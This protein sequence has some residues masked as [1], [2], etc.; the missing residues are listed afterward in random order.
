MKTGFHTH[1]SAL[2]ELYLNGF[3][4]RLYIK[5]DDLIHPIVSGNKW[6]KLKFVIIKAQAEGKNHLVTFGGAYSNH[7]LATACAGATLGLKTSCFLRADEAIA[8]HYLTA[9]KLYGMN[10]IPV[11]RE[12]YR[13]K[14]ELFRE[15]FGADK[16]A[17][18]VAEGGESTEAIQGVTEIIEELEFEPDYILHA[19]ATATTALGLGKGIQSKGWKTKVLAIAVLKNAAEQRDKV[20]QNNLSDTIDILDGFHHGGYAKTSEPLMLFLQ[21][22]IASTGIMLDPVYTGKA[23]FALNEINPKGRIVFLHTGGTMGIFSDAYAKLIG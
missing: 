1:C 23:L 22:T 5:R 7:L 21:Q 3:E 15:H 14:E 2:E 4:G 12:G 10:L 13:H 18:Y 9:A 16:Q 8:N 19:S 20:Q 17:Y 6:R 11:S